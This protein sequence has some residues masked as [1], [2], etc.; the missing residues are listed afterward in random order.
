MGVDTSGVYRPN[1]P[2]KPPPIDVLEWALATALA[3]VAGVALVGTW[4]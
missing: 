3:V 2:P 4:H 1:P